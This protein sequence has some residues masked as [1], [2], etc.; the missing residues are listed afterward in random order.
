[1]YI[2]SIVLI[3]KERRSYFTRSRGKEKAALQLSAG[4]LVFPFFMMIDDMV[5]IQLYI[6]QKLNGLSRRLLEGGQLGKEGKYIM[7]KLYN[8]AA[9]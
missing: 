4:R 6:T 9:T 7:A 5:P 1:M 3:K 8:I 2:S